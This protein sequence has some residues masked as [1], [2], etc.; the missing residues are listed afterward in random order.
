MVG[1]IPFIPVVKN[2]FSSTCRIF[3]KVKLSL[4]LMLARISEI[5]QKKLLRALIKWFIYMA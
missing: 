3:I 1:D 5:I 4:F 2:G